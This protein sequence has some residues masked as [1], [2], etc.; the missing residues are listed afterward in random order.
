MN[1]GCRPAKLFKSPDFWFGVVT[2]VIVTLLAT[3]VFG[4]F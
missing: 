3:K 1:G 4:L 2:G